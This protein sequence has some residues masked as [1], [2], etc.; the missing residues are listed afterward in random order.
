MS[1]TNQTKNTNSFTN[2]SKNTSVFT[3]SDKSSQTYYLLTDILDYILVGSS[4]NEYLVLT[5]GN[6]YSNLAKS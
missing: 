6:V 4:E 5:E 1:F 2:T 3:N